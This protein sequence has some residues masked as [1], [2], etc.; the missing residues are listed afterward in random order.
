[1]GATG[2]VYVIGVC[3]STVHVYRMCRDSI[4]L[5][6]WGVFHGRCIKVRMVEFERFYIQ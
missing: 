5:M 1:M 6:M 2:V 4:V 3:V